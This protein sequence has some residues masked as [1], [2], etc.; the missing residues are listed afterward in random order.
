M[1]AWEVVEEGGQFEGGDEETVAVGFE[2]T[3]A[4]GGD[5]DGPA[6]VDFLLDLVVELMDGLA[7]VVAG[8]GIK[9]GLAE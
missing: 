5:A 4:A 6:E 1:E 2:M 3:A 8:G 9:H 7:N